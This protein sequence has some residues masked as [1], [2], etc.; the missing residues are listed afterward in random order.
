MPFN[1]ADATAVETQEPV[2]RSGETQFLASEQVRAWDYL[3]PLQ[4]VQQFHVN[5]L[6]FRSQTGLSDLSGIVL[7]LQ[8]DCPA[9]GWRHIET[10]DISKALDRDGFV[11]LTVPPGAVGDAITISSWVLLDRPDTPGTMDRVAHLRGSRLHTGDM[12]WRVQLEGNGAGFPTEAIDFRTIGLPEDAPW[13]LAMR[14]ADLDLPFMSAVRLQVNTGH[15]ASKALR[16]GSVP[17]LQSAL[18]HD[19]LLQML[20]NV[21]ESVL[22]EHQDS[23]PDES[24][25]EVMDGLCANFVG[26]GLSEACQDLTDDQPQFLTRL[27]GGV[28]LFGEV[29]E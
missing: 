11:E 12:I 23:W 10:A 6:K 16:T 4:V 24:L 18:F 21:R 22:E 9:T 29:G 26:V 27:K 5:D 19:V 8:V 3:T 15:P 7:A 13:H 17:Q 2:L 1:V 28:R 14:G 20:L 25:G